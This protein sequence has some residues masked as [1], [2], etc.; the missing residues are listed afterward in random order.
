MGLEDASVE[1]GALYFLHQAAAND[2]RLED[3]TFL[4]CSASKGAALFITNKG[5]AGIHELLMDKVTV[6]SATTSNGGGIYA[7][8][9]IIYMRNR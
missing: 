9:T 3:I 4:R 5:T 8:N 2:Y 1:G 6:S 7:R